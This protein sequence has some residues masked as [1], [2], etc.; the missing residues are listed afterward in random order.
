MNEQPDHIDALIARYLTGEASAAEI[1][2]LEEWKNK[3]AE[4]VLHFQQ[5]ELIFNGAAPALDEGDFDT[6]SAW[7]S[8]RQRLSSRRKSV[9]FNSRTIDFI[10]FL[11]LAAALAIFVT[12]GLFIYRFISSP[13]MEPL[14]LATDRNVLSDSLPG[15]ID[16]VLNKKTSIEYFFDEKKNIHSATLKGEAYFDVDNGDEEIFIVQADE[17]FVKDVGTSFNVQAY[18]GS[19]SIEV[20]VDEGEVLFYTSSNPGIALK[21][22]ERGIYN[23]KKKTF[24]IVALEPNI[25]SYAN[26]SFIF[27]NF[28]LEEVVETL[29]GV[30]E[31]RISIGENLRECRLTVS[32]ENERI[33]EIAQVIAETLNLSVSRSGNVIMLTGKGCEEADAI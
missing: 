7:D 2:F 27:N 24:A 30:Y 32:F 33:D 3:R 8:V 29:N 26:R 15:G 5:F 28:S 12:V 10:P 16:V 19:D 22:N 1:T 21:A 25:T 11:R 23:K 9:F 4:N 18:P 17:T 31:T 14:R 13:D 6:D 20:L